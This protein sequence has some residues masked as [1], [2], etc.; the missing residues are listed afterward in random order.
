MKNY[1]HLLK[2]YPPRNYFLRIFQFLFWLLS[3]YYDEKPSFERL[4]FAISDSRAIMN[5]F[6]V[7]EKIHDNF[8]KSVLF[9]E[10][11][12]IQ[13]LMYLTYITSFCHIS[14]HSFCFIMALC[15]YN[16][17]FL[18]I[19]YNTFYTCTMIINLMRYKIELDEINS[20]N[21]KIK[22]EEKE[23][24]KKMIKL[25][26]II[27]GFNLP[28]AL[29]GTGLINIIIGIKLNKATEGLLGFLASIIQ[30]YV[31]S[32]KHLEEIK[33]YNINTNKKVK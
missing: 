26:V 15:G 2:Y 18:E 11:N 14:I 31:A 21:E 20:L 30:F 13:Q 23:E 24:R 12:K 6:S 27:I 10:N 16:L 17:H 32:L 8:S 4:S 3:Y 22:T 9:K 5:L 7:L 28:L 19:L 25:G 1:I 33:F 29:N